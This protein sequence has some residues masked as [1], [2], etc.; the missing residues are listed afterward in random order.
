MTRRQIAPQPHEVLFTSEVARWLQ[1]SPRSVERHFTPFL[2]GRYL[3]A[4]ILARIEQMARDRAKKAA[5]PQGV[6]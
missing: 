4:Q 3:V 5:V 2:P 6:S 1:I